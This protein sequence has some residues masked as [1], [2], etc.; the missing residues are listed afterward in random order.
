MPAFFLLPP[1]KLPTAEFLR[2]RLDHT[3][4][5]TEALINTALV[6][7]SAALIQAG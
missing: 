5:D 6:V 4:D 3:P 1:E 2:E 7:I